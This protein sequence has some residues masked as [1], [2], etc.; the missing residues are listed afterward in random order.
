MMAASHTWPCNRGIHAVIFLGGV[1]GS[2]SAL[3]LGHSRSDISCSG[4]SK[5]RSST[6]VAST[7]RRIVPDAIATLVA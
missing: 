1:V 7:R 6:F 2:C 3:Q 4:L 5:N